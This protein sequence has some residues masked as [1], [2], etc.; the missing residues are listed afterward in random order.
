[1]MGVE[2]QW[3]AGNRTEWN[4][5]SKGLP[6]MERNG[7]GAAIACRE[8]NGMD[9]MEW[10]QQWPAG[11]GMERNGMEREQ[12]WPARNGMEWNWSSNGLPGMEWN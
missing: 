3:P 10:E 8:W 2:Q 12:Q 9:G 6:G 11:N 1:M 5:S 7:M 4:G